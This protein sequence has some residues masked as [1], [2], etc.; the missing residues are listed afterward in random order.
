MAATCDGTSTV[1]GGATGTLSGRD[2]VTGVVV[3]AVNKS[4]MAIETC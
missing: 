1:G 3:Q 4:V 2:G